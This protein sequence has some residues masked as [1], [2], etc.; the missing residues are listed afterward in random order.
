MRALID[1][2]VV[3]WV[4]LALTV[5]GFFGTIVAVVLWLTKPWFRYNPDTGRPEVW[6]KSKKD[7]STAGEDTREEEGNTT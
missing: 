7:K 4:E 2:T 1:N 3:R 6:D 5:V